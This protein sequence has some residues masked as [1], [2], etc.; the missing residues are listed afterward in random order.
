MRRR[1]RIYIRATKRELRQTGCIH[2]GAD[3]IPLARRRNVNKR[4]AS[5]ARAAFAS[6]KA[7]R[8]DEKGRVGTRDG[9]GNE[10]GSLSLSAALS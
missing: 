6:E 9:K 8:R 3:D 7:A 2:Y 4:D 1:S 5:W 10:T